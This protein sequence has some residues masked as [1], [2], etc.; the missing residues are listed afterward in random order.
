MEERL[1]SQDEDNW[2]IPVFCEKHQENG[3]KDY[4]SGGMKGIQVQKPNLIKT[5]K[6]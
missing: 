2:F 3:W 1:Q 6:D 5:I 4:N